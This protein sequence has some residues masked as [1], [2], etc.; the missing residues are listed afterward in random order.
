MPPL[1]RREQLGGNRWVRTC[2]VPAA[3]AL[4][5]HAP[6]ASVQ[7]CP[8]EHAALLHPPFSFKPRPRPHLRFRRSSEGLHS[9]PSCAS[10]SLML[11]GVRSVPQERP[12]RRL[13]R[14]MRPSWSG[15]PSAVWYLAASGPWANSTCLH[16]GSTGAADETEDLVNT[17]RPKSR[18]RGSKPPPGHWR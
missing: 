2:M 10:S 1:S 4:A 3:S 14:A 5:M 11:L 17:G 6:P 18:R 15:W 13:G 8:A 9:S 7:R 12:S 16:V